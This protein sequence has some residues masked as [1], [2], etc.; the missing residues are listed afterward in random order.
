MSRLI[1]YPAKGRGCARR[2]RKVGHYHIRF[3]IGAN[4]WINTLPWAISLQFTCIFRKTRGMLTL[5]LAQPL[6]PRSTERWHRTL[7]T[8]SYSLPGAIAIDASRSPA[9]PVY[10]HVLFA[11]CFWPRDSRVWRRLTFGIPAGAQ[12]IC[13]PLRPQPFDN[14]ATYSLLT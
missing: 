14:G 10:A 2:R 8:P 6:A 11:I 13:S 5:R 12:P 9:R 1:S 7:P 3:R 4:A